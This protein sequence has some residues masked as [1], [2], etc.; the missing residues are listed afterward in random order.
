MYLDSQDATLVDVHAKR[1]TGRIPELSGA[2][3]IEIEASAVA[4]G[5]AV[6][7]YMTASPLVDSVGAALTAIQVDGEV[8]SEFQLY[9]PFNSETESRAWG[10]ADLTSNHVEI[11]AP[12]MTLEKVTGRIEFDNDV[13]QAAGLSADLLKTAHFYRLFW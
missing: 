7:D 8:M 9:I 5:N 10:F 13:V 1:I 3:H 12:P 6:R 4:Q 2:G 11:E